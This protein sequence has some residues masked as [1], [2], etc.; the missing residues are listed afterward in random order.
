MV[1]MNF[2]GKAK[3]SGLIWKVQLFGQSNL[4]KTERLR[5]T[6]FDIGYLLTGKGYQDVPCALFPLW[7]CPSTPS[8]SFT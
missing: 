7:I 2:G 5:L 3:R 4:G 1:D 6:Q 8:I